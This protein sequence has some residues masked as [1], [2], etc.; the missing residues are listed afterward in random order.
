MA[1]LMSAAAAAPSVA[2]EEATVKA[3]AAWQGQGR[4]YQ[5]GPHQATFVGSLT[6]PMYVETENGLIR[7]GFMTCPAIVQIGLEDGKQRGQARCSIA[8]KNGAQIYAEITCTGV[9][10]VGCDGELKLTGGTKQFAGISGGGKVTIR[11]DSRQI[12]ALSD[13]AAQEQGTGSLYVPELH[14]KL[15]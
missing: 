3:L 9:Y 6:G 8:A 14:Y 11:S 7:S 15:P 1:V 13:N 10:L 12:A 4:T 5:T 2:G